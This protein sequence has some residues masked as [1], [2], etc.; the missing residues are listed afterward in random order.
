MYRRMLLDYS[1][2]KSH[3]I[4]GILLYA[5]RDPQIHGGSISFTIPDIHPHDLA[6]LVD[7]EG[8]AVRA[9]HHCTQP[10]M[11]RLGVP[12]TTRA[13]SYIY[14]Q[15]DDVDQLARRRQEAQQ[16]VAQL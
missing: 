11:D 8:I 12:A 1:L 2:E 3:D 9:G 7:R 4:P 5:P 14:N 13:S 15:P 10:L 6:T 16:V